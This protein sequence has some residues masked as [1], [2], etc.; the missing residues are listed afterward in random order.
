M[1]KAHKQNTLVYRK[2]MKVKGGGTTSKNVLISALKESN[3][4]YAPADKAQTRSVMQSSTRPPIH[5]DEFLIKL[6]ISETKRVEAQ[7]Q[8]T[9]LYNIMR[10]SP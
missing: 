2:V 8:D 7:S 5:H 10:T 3:P 6:I 9:P 4:M 1:N